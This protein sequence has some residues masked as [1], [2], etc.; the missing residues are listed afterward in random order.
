MRRVLRAARGTAAVQENRIWEMQTPEGVLPLR[1]R[2][3][4]R[5]RHIALR[6]TSKTREV[7]LVVPPGCKLEKAYDFARAHEGWIRRQLEARPPDIPFAGGQRIPLRGVEH[8]IRHKNQMRGLVRQIPGKD[9]ALPELVVPALPEHLARRLRDWLKAEARRDLGRA[10]KTHADRLGVT[11]MRLS[12]RDQASRW[13]S[14]SSRGNL[15][16]SWRLILAPP[17]VLDYV[18]AHEVAHLLEMNHSKRFWSHVRVAC[19]DMKNARRWLKANGH[20][21]HR[22]GRNTRHE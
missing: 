18:A 8:I 2:P 6:L 1:V 22:Y 21:L 20:Q 14:C 4:S 5:A 9:E 10:V 19:P 7:A 16:F 17:E 11:P 3:S 12:V 15:N 13:G